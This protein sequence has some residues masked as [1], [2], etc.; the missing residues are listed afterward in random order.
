[1]QLHEFQGDILLFSW[2]SYF[3]KKDVEEKQDT[4]PEGPMQTILIENGS[5]KS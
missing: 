4:G 2:G 1:M 5:C 3:G